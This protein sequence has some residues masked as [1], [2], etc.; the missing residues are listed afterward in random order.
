MTISLTALAEK[1]GL[2]RRRVAECQSA[3]EELLKSFEVASSKFDDAMAK[4]ESFK[5]GDSNSKD[6]K[7]KESLASAV[8]AAREEMQS[9][10]KKVVASAD[11]VNSA[12]SLLNE[13]EADYRM[14]EDH[15][16]V[17]Q[18]LS[19]STG[20]HV[21]TDGARLN[22][23]GGS[24]DR[25][26]VLPP[27]AEQVDV[28]LGVF[29][30]CTMIAQLDRLSPEQAVAM[31]RQ[32]FGNERVGSVLSSAMQ[33]NTH[34]SGGSLVAGAFLPR[35]IEL[36]RAQAIMRR[37]GVPTVPLDDGSLTIPKITG[38]S[39]S[40]YTGEGSDA[41][42]S[43]LTTG[44]MKLVA[45]EMVT[46]V[47]CS[48]KLLRSPSAGAAN[49]IRDDIIRSA[50]LCEDLHF[51]RGLDSG[52]GPTGMRYLAPSAN[53]LTMNGTVNLT[54]VTNDL[55][56]LE[57]ALMAANVGM[58]NA[59]W[60]MA[61]RTFVYLS[62]LRDGNGNIAF[63]EMGM[64]MLRGKPVH[65]TTQIP[66]N[67]STNQSEVYLFDAAE[68]VIGDAPAISMEASNV[69]AY[70]NG[71]SVVAAFSKRQVVTRLVI[72]NDFGA[73]HNEAIAV[74]TGVTWGVV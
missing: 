66:V 72:E 4:L 45:K 56:R 18:S 28:D 34:T 19:G 54:N 58:T 30:Q 24:S 52:A 48:E 43:E 12:I 35:V 5:E 59:N 60:A 70:Q 49:I 9:A 46:I 7:S 15:N 17:E 71:A 68:L 40:Y 47:P 11:S 1:I 8:N 20:R 27:S 22:S 65:I 69:A 26:N 67:L 36:L 3:R 21:G 51:I 6:A 73:R 25:I 74:L 63:P 37:A 44:N 23:A 10:R 39:S 62:T 31:A 29:L 13:L 55:A 16:R 50:A 53:I 32:Q 41:T 42:P 57:L 33:A 64:M 14:A 2:Q 61:P 38:G